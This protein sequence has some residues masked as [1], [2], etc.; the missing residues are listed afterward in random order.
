MTLSNEF[1][2][3]LKQKEGYRRFV[4][5]C[6][7]GKE[8]IGYGHVLINDEN[9]QK[10]DEF[11]AE[12]LLMQD[13]DKI[14]CKLHTFVGD[15]SNNLQQNEYEAIL[16]LLYNWGV[17]RFIPS[18][19]AKSLKEGN[20]EQAAHEFLNICNVNGK[21]CRGLQIRRYE[22]MLVFKYGWD[23]LKVLG[24]IKCDNKFIF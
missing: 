6:P 9:Y 1:L 18:K 10:I 21:P 12:K 23:A 4:Y 8:T 7:A 19:L 16:S 2:N 20:K 17:S 3:Y 13:I 15:L 14:Q 11:I 24:Q 5:T 22:E